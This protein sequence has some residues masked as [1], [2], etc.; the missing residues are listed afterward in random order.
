[1]NYV[2]VIHFVR[3]ISLLLFVAKKPEYFSNYRQS[4]IEFRRSR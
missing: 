3:K 2:I 1:M 4:T